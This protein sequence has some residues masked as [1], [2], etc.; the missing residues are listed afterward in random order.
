MRSCLPGSLPSYI[1]Y[2]IYYM[3]ISLAN[4]IVVVVVSAVVVVVVVVI[5]HKSQD[6][7]LA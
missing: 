2:I 1:H 5:V 6:T 7:D 4:K 3:Y